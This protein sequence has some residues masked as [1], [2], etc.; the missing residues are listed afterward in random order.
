MRD[1]QHITST[2]GNIENHFPVQSLMYRE[3]PLWPIIRQQLTSSLFWE[4]SAIPDDTFRNL[5]LRSIPPFLARFIHKAADCAAVSMLNGKFNGKSEVLFLTAGFEYVP[6]SGAF[7]NKFLDPVK[8]LLDKRRISYSDVE[9]G[10][11]GKEYT[12]KLFPT[13]D[14]RGPVSLLLKMALIGDARLSVREKALLTDFSA[15]CANNQVAIN[16]RDI[17]LS[18]VRIS[19]LSKLFEKMLSVLQPKVCMF[20][21]YYQDTTMAAAHACRKLGIRTVEL[22]HSVINEDDW[23]WCKWSAIPTQG[24]STMPDIFW[25]WGEKYSTLLDCWEKHPGTNLTPRVGG[26]LWIGKWRQSTDNPVPEITARLRAAGRTILYTVP[27]G[28]IK[29]ITEWFPPE[30]EEAVRRSPP[31]WKWH[32]RLHYKA[33]TAMVQAVKQ[34]AE[35]LG[36]NVYVHHADEHHLYHLFSIVDVHISQTSSTIVEAEA[37][38]LPNLILGEVGKTWFHEEIE[39]GCYAYARTADEVLAFVLNAKKISIG[40]AGIITDTSCAEKLLDSLNLVGDLA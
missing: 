4:R 31:D 32:I 15:L 38:G 7:Y 33:D 20:V 1:Y 2:I 34:Y 40:L 8:E 24:Y 28:D 3:I 27:F 30:F 9:L 37:F 11:A 21:C 19:S 35:T 29:L 16:M 25:T 10:F 5:V 36:Q 13:I 17:I 14:L 6:F 18:A 39:S 23:S 22:Q 12:P 26:N